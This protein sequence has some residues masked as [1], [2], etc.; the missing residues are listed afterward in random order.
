MYKYIVFTL[1]LGA[2]SR[3]A[4]AAN[5]GN[6]RSIMLDFIAKTDKLEN[7]QLLKNLWTTSQKKQFIS[8]AKALGFSDAN[9]KIIIES[10]NMQLES[11]DIIR[12]RNYLTYVLS[13]SDKDQKIA[14]MD[15]AQLD[16]HEINSKHIKR[17]IV[18]EN[19]IQNQIKS[20]KLAT[21]AEQH[22]H[23]ELYYGCRAFRSNDVNKNATRD[24]K[25]FNLALGLGTLGASYTYYN[26]DK[27]INAEWFGKLGYDIGVTL[28]FSYVSGRIQTKVTDSQVVKSLKSYFFGRVIGITDVVIYD[29]IF[30]NEQEKAQ[31]RIDELKKDPKFK[32]QIAHLLKSYEERGLYRKYKNEIISTLKKIPEHINLGLKGNSIDANNVD[33]NNLTHADLERE[34]VQEVL[35]AAAM[36]QIYNESKG[37]W[38][39]TGDGGLDRYVFNTVFYAVQIPKSIA[40]NFITYRMLCMGQDNP[41]QSFAKAV[42]FNVSSSFIVNQALYG[43]RE[44]AINQ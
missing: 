15:L 8:D 38:V 44:K 33:W 43:Y 5:A 34:D 12:V 3:S 18:H 26:M 36:A 7:V 35:V 39:D 11:A 28:M 6:C 41:K 23:E 4:N 17:F 40:Q 13:L 2:L 19:K 30:N 10:L 31:K 42:L 21:K 16:D 14:L 9:I 24:F 27:D 20:K 22:R 25:R 32:E 37:Q 29:P 1:I